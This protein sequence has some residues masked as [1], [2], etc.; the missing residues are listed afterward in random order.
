MG[1]ALQADAVFLST[2]EANPPFPVLFFAKIRKKLKSEKKYGGKYNECKNIHIK[3]H[4]IVRNRH[5]VVRNSHV[6]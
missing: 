4:R 3:I 2:C 6:G 5:V 1:T